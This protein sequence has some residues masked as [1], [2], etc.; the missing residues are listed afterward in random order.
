MKATLLTGRNKGKVWLVSWYQVLPVA[1]SVK[2]RSSS[3]KIASAWRSRSAYSFFTSPRMR[4]PRPGPGNGWRETISGGSPRAT[5]NSRTSSLNR[6]RSGSSSFRPSCSG[7]PPTVWWLLVVY[8][9]FVVGAA[10]FD[11]VGVDRALG[12]EGRALV[13][14]RASLQ[15]G[16]FGLEHVDEQA[17]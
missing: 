1:G 16:R 7:R 11:D 14:T 10:R 15:L 6:S 17:A 3:M 4:T 5:P 12:Q 8:G 9:F 13:A 2:L